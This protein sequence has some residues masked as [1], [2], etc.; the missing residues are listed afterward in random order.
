MNIE[1]DGDSEAAVAL[2]L[3]RMI[4]EAEGKL[5]EK[6]AWKDTDRAWILD[7]YTECLAAVDGLRI[8]GADEDEDDKAE[9]DEAEEMEEDSEEDDAEEVGREAED[10]EPKPAG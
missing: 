5:T 3:L 4:A 8:E 9:S 6:G 2:A 7:T 1:I 10:T